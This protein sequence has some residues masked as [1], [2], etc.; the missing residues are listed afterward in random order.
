MD[1]PKNIAQRLARPAAVLGAGV[2]GAAAAQLLGRLGATGAVVYDEKGGSSSAK[3]EFGA[4][5]AAR[6]DLVIYSPG[7][8]QNHPW[9]LAA[10]RGGALCLGEMDFASLFWKHPIVAVT[11]TNGKTTLTEF[12]AFAHKRNGREAVAAGNN[13]Y[14]LSRI[15]ELAGSR[16]PL[17]VCEVSSFQAEDMRHFSPV[18]LLWT[19][20]DEDHLDRH[21]DLETYFRA[22][23]KLISRLG[24]R[25]LLIVGES[26]V[27][28]AARFGL[29]L[30][31]FI[32][33][34]TR[35]E[36]ADKVPPESIFASYPQRE[37]YALARRY[38]LAEG[39]PER[40]LEDAARMFTPARHRLA[41]VAEIGGVAYWDDSKGTNF[42]A[43][44][45]ALQ[46]LAGPI[47]WIGGGQ[48]KGGDLRAFA[49]RVAARVKTAS[50]IGETAPA[51]H[52]VFQEKGVPSRIFKTLPEAVVAIAAGAVAGDA[53]LL[54]PGFA[55]FDMFNSYADRGLAFEQ[56]VLAVKNNAAARK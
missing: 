28:A 53:V 38:W 48:G 44:L 34:A 7:F 15:F 24:Q 27:A 23:Y 26:V 20:F 56:T 6:H 14:P 13:G 31:S 37:N 8:A 46:T 35:D 40:A 10:R 50:L 45:A 5:E 3:T 42:H 25:R 47:H 16:I 51:L 29:E 54:S 52:E 22:K 49:A 4:A 39:L 18:A 19:N 33:V 32:E 21:A 30:P 17:A 55:S 12:L 43:V 36:V 9:L 2:S 41:K 1:I 11:G